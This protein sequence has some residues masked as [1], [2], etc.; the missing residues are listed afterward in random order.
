MRR[1]NASGRLPLRRRRYIIA[2]VPSKDILREP[3][4]LPVGES[5]K[6]RKSLL[7]G[8]AK[9]KVFSCLCD[10]GKINRH[11]CYKAQEADI[12]KSWGAFQFNGPYTGKKIEKIQDV[13]LPL[14]YIKFMKEHN[15]GEGDIGE[16]WLVLFPLEELQK[17]ND[18]YETKIFLPGHIIGTNGGGELYG[19][20]AKGNYYNVPVMMEKEYVSML[21]SDIHELPEKINEL[22]R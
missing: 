14:P 18:D 11:F 12:I 5:R 1:L 21:G 10:C 9:Q 3:F 16:T 20:D 15:G 19:I 7:P 13:V 4:I 6:R 8:R 17:I 22:W 2:K